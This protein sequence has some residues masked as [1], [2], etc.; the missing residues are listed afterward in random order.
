MM[1][2]RPI[3]ATSLVLP[4][5]ALLIGLAAPS[6]G[7]AER[8]DND[9]DE[10]SGGSGSAGS[11]SSGDGTCS[12]FLGKTCAAD[13]FCDYPDD[14]CGG[15]DGNGTCVPKPAVCDKN[16][17]PVCGCDGTIHGNACEANAAGFDVNGLEGGC[18]PPQDTFACGPTFCV[19]ATHYCQHYLSDT[20]GPDDYACVPLPEGCA[21][22][23]CNCLSGEQC[24][25]MC[26]QGQDGS[27][28]LTCPGG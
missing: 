5:V 26:S 19:I 11:S 10:G 25:F 21:G 14:T 6:C 2:L 27:F 20:G 9:A 16:Y 22:T 17:D 3:D 24:G 13:S 12:A 18:P 1:R 4:A 23:D 7:N 15:L 8:D 28:T